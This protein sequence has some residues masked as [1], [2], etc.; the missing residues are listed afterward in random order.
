MIASNLVSLMVFKRVQHTYFY[1]QKRSIQMFLTL[2][3]NAARTT[4]VALC[5]D[6]VAGSWDIGRISVTATMEKAGLQ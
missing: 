5:D 6:I 3:S 2:N 4:F 1:T